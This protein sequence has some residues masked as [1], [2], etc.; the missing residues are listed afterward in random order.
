MARA[1]AFLSALVV[2]ATSTTVTIDVSHTIATIPPTFASFGWEMDGM[3][4]LL[5]AMADPRFAATAK[6]LSPAII[7]VGGITGD[8]PCVYALRVPRHH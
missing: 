6:H 8:C 4:S 1:I 5:S 7:R 2:G 3:I